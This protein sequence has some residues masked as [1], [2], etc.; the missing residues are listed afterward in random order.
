MSNTDPGKRSPS[1]V[2]VALAWIVL[3]G[4]ILNFGL[5]LRDIGEDDIPTGVIVSRVLT[6]VSLLII[7]IYAIK[8]KG[9]VNLLFKIVLVLILFLI[10]GSI[11][12][13]IL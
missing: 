10:I 11:G 1:F 9:D 5:F 3:I 2:F 12:H 6:S 7:C 8:K 13:L 4:T